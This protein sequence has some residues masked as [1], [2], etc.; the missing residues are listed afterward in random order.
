MDHSDGQCMRHWQTSGRQELAERLISI[1]PCHSFVSRVEATFVINGVTNSLKGTKEEATF[2]TNGVANSSDDMQW[3]TE[4]STQLLWREVILHHWSKKKSIGACAPAT[5]CV[6]IG[7]LVNSQVVPLWLHVF[8]VVRSKFQLQCSSLAMSLEQLLGVQ[9]W[10]QGDN[11]RLHTQINKFFP[12]CSHDLF[13]EE[14][15]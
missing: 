13:T 11:P 12:K 9:I 6:D 3:H 5:H 4:S 8:V 1:S 2:V 15:F 10:D 7:C 14:K